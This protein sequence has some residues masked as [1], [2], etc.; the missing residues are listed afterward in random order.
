MATQIARFLDYFGL[1]R[2]LD[3]MRR[4]VGEAV[5]AKGMKKIGGLTYGEYVRESGLG[6]DDFQRGKIGAAYNRFTML[7]AH[8]E[9]LPEGAPLGPG[10][11]EHSLTL[12]RLARC[13]NN[14]GQPA[15][16]EGYLRKA[17]TVVEALLRQQPE[18]KSYLRLRCLLLT[19]LADVLTAQGKY[20]QA[21]EAYEE[22]LEI[23]KQQGDLRQQ[24][25]AQVQ[26]GTL[27]L[28]QRSY[29]EAQSRYVEALQL[30][31]R[32][33]EPATEA[34][35]WHQL[36]MVAQHQ[37]ALTEAERC[38]RNALAIK[39]QLGDAA[40][41]ANTCNQ[42]AIAAQAA[43]RPVEA[44]G[45]FMRDLELYEQANPGGPDSARTLHNLANLLVNE[46]QASRAATTRLAEAKRY[47][48]QAL[49]IRE[50]LDA[51]E[52]NRYHI[53]QQHGQLIAAIAAAAQRDVQ[54]REAV[55]AAL[56]DLEEDGWKIAAATQRIWSGERS[57]ASPVEELDKQ[58]ALLILRVLETIEQPAEAQV[59]TT[60][61]IIASL[62]VTIREAL[63][64]GD[65]AAFQQAF[66]ALSSEDQQ[67]VVEAMQYLQNQEEEDEGDKTGDRKL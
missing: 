31:Q 37:Q 55:E 11:Y 3:E 33:G 32:L 2:E 25:V 6:E 9:A 60:E 22:S 47:A 43:D 8:I 19:D 65:E 15:A 10:S 26:L 62:P 29:A 12:T 50:T 20:S 51:F 46:V 1:F 61:Q 67:L 59:K 18:S 38:Y 5:T 63:A 27:A 41:A 53:Y 24:G 30:F 44:E 49:A 21:R 14:S 17:L 39:E 45:W 7:L 58:D 56:P 54:A 66:E 42:L 36:G 16:A 40:G 48:E 23:T 57:W 28:R 34:I 13:I 64:Q 35:A 4:R 52:G